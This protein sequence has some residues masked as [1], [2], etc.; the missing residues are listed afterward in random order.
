MTKCCS[1][2]LGILYRANKN[3]INQFEKQSESEEKSQ[4]FMIALALIL[5]LTFCTTY[6]NRTRDSSVKGRR[7]NPLTNAAVFRNAKIGIVAFLTKF[8]ETHVK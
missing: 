4:N 3:S 6:G 8:F 2:I 5:V 1:E 7:L